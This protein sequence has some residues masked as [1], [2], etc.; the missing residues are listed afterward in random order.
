MWT[1]AD[2]A[3]ECLDCRRPFSFYFDLVARHWKSRGS[4]NLTLHRICTLA[5]KQGCNF[6]SVE[7]ALHR[8][9]V[10]EEIDALDEFYGG[11]GEAQAITFGFFG[12]ETSP[13][14]IGTVL[15][16]ALVGSV[17][18]INY[19]PKGSA[20]YELS[21][22]FEAVMTPPNLTNGEGLRQRLLNNFIC[23]ETEFKRKVRGREFGLKGFYFCQQ[24]GKTNVC[25]HASLRMAINSDGSAVPPISNVAINKQLKLNPP[26]AGLQIGQIADIIRANTK[27]DPIIIDCARLGK[28]TDALAVISA[29]VQSGAIVLLVFST[30]NATDH[31]VTVFGHTRNS[32][33]W[34]PQAIPG[35]SGPNTA[36][37]YTNSSWIDHL[38]IHDD[39][40]GPYHTLSSRALE[41]D[42]NVQARHIIAV[43]PFKTNVLPN[44]AEALAAIILRNSIQNVA[45]LGK[46]AWF[47]YITQN[48]WTYIARSILIGRD[49]YQNHLRSS[50]AHDHTALTEEE[51]KLLDGLPD[52]FWMVEFS[53]PALFTGNRSKLGEVIVAATSTGGPPMELLQAFRLPSMLILPAGGGSIHPISMISHSPIYITQPH[54]N[55]W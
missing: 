33:E 40:L 29:Y 55:Q 34:H 35:Y 54:E 6:V 9:D 13:A 27:C 38:V 16:D 19:R 17:I 4:N 8:G 1:E 49:Q 39:N 15:D 37:Y 25:A 18:L 22:I 31:V 47:D 41:V 12:G 26:F 24:N 53:L 20:A 46:G 10:R 43:H 45:G 21:Y 50:V 11:D 28:P 42:P 36:Q 52:F 14:V 23:R 44:Y 30:S 7:C 51:I 48:S 32:D 3:E 2:T 5:R